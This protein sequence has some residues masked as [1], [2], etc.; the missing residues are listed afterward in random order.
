MSKDFQETTVRIIESW[1][2]SIVFADDL[3]RVFFG[4]TIYTALDQAYQ[5]GRKAEAKKRK[6]SISA[7]Y[8]KRLTKRVPD[9]S[10]CTCMA[11]QTYQGFAQVTQSVSPKEAQ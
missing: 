9:A 1:S 3:A 10:P 6:A 11:Q 5:A 2:D 7:R 4:A 8:Q